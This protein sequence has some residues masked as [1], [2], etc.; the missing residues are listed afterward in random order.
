LKGQNLR[1]VALLIVTGACYHATIET[2]LTPSAQTIEKHW[3]SGW[4]F[5]LVPP[6][7]VQTAQKCPSGVAKV[8]TQL[9]FT[10]QL[11]SILTLGIYSP[12]DITVT[13]AEGRT[14][15]LPII[16]SGVDKRAGLEQAV[17]LSLKMHQPVL[18]AY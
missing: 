15:S 7:P 8:D 14:S 17:A 5:G 13:C 9:S 2:G 6:S 16:R 18:F 3:A 4:I 1:I 10:N 11:V 12:M